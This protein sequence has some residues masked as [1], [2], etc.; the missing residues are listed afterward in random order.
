MKKLSNLVK[1][2]YEKCLKCKNIKGFDFDTGFCFECGS[3]SPIAFE[4]TSFLQDT[5]FEAAKESFLIFFVLANIIGI[6]WGLINYVTSKEGFIFPFLWVM[7]IGAAISVGISIIIFSQVSRTHAVNEVARSLGLSFS[8]DTEV[9]SKIFYYLKDYS[10]FSGKNNRRF[11]NVLCG[12]IGQANIW[13]SDYQYVTGGQVGSTNTS[14]VHRGTFLLF[15][16]DELSLPSFLLK[17]KGIDD[18][19]VSLFSN[20]NIKFPEDPN[21]SKHY[22]LFGEDEQKISK[23]F[24]SSIRAFCEQHRGLFIEG[25]NDSFIIY[26]KDVTIN[27]D[28]LAEFLNLGKA[29]FRL[30]MKH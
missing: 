26:K 15:Q 5:P 1:V 9:F 13:I 21:F 6:I 2:R 22:F 12:N 4:K 28:D 27:A 16:S 7:L 10:I 23:L 25:N 11:S 19:I 17:T 20:K 29:L 18:K 3:I 8:D 24:N 14:T 30:F